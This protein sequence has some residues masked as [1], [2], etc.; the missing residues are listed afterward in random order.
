MRANCN[1]GIVD[2]FQWSS[3]SLTALPVQTV[4]LDGLFAFE[5]FTGTSSLSHCTLTY[6]FLIYDSSSYVTYSDSDLTFISG[7]QQVNIASSDGA[8]DGITDQMKIRAAVS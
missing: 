1:T 4:F 5:Y 6:E 2:N 3:N 8:L 7:T